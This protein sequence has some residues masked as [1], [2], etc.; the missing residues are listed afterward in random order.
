MYKNIFYTLWHIFFYFVF[1][2]NFLNSGMQNVIG[3]FADKAVSFTHSS[4]LMLWR[5]LQYLIKTGLFS[6]LQHW[7][8]WLN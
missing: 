3:D 2:F 8:Y 4:V 1:I 6:E 7:S 5:G